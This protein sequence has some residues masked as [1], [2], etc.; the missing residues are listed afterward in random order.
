MKIKLFLFSSITCLFLFAGCSHKKNDSSTE[1]TEQNAQNGKSGE[2]IQ[3][4]NGKNLNGWTPKF[5]GFKLGVNYKNTFRVENGLLTVAYDNYDQ[6]NGHYGHLF[7]KKPFSSYKLRVVYRFIGKQVP[8]G[9]GWA[10]RNNGL[11]LFCQKPQTM[12]LNQ[13]Y[14]ISVETQLL[15]GNGEDPRPTAN[16]CTVGTKVMIGD[17][18]NQ[19]HCVESTSKTYAGDQ[20]VAVE[21]VVRSNGIVS[22]IVNG[23]TVFTYSKTRYSKS[24]SAAQ[25]LGEKYGRKFLNR[26]YIAIQAESAPIQFKSIEI[27]PLDK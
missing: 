11:M 10:Y 6:F 3:L 14:P 8:G 17:H 2:W 22:N 4:F 13:D 27:L 19:R 12:N 5:S 7:Y 1:T 16:V 18:L 15:G 23:D 24:D 21:V 9:P 25:A 20:W 26:G